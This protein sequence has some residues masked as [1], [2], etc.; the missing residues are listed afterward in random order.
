VASKPT[1][2]GYVVANSNATT[3]TRQNATTRGSLATTWR[4][5][6]NRRK[7]ANGGYSHHWNYR[8]TI[9]GQRRA[10]YGGNLEKLVA[11]NPARW[12]IY[13]SNSATGRRERQNGKKEKR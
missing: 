4:I 13:I 10:V 2:N 11:L 9:N 1:S 5:E 3:R 6:I 8:F 12:N 7:L